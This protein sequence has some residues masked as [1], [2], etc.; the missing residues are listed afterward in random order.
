M[1]RHQAPKV[2]LTS[3]DVKHKTGSRAAWE[4]RCQLP[5]TCALLVVRHTHNQTR[6]PEAHREHQEHAPRTGTESAHREHDHHRLLHGSR[7]IP[8]A[9]HDPPVSGVALTTWRHW[10][11]AC[12]GGQPASAVVGP[13]LPTRASPSISAREH[14]TFKSQ[15]MLAFL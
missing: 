2:K 3:E 11:P 14:E 13:C 8:G 10:T 5:G 9:G 7:E 15:K 12:S 6:A 1:P 4:H